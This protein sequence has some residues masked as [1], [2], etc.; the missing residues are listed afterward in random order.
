MVFVPANLAD[1]ATPAERA[2]LAA[3][4]PIE[5]LRWAGDSFGDDLVVTAGFSDATLVHLVSLAI[6][7]A[8]VVLLDTG[9]LFA[10]TEWFAERLRT[11]L[12][13]RLRSVH[14]EPAAERDLWQTDPDAC[15]HARKV[16][17]LERALR[18]KRAWVTGVR[19]SDNGARAGTPVV[20]DDLVRRVTKINPIAM[21]GPDDVAAHRVAYDLPEHPLAD[22]GYR[23][24]G[25]WPC[26]APV[27]GGEHER[28]GRW[29]GSD[30]SECGLHGTAVPV[31]IGAPS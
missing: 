4:H 13:L 1:L 17:P 6:P 29:R 11:R 20:H 27:S 7:D 31:T 26:T 25:C 2:D 8:D 14:P 19:R 28:A 3:R 16:E 9:Y 15:C 24:I 22:R 5:V 12:G 18:A 21:W 23:S 30:K 10:E